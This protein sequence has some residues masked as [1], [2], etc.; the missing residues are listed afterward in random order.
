MR[1][2]LAAT[3]QNL[4]DIFANNQYVFEI[5]L[6]QR[7]Y[8]WT[9]EHID[10][11]LD[12]LVDAM[13]RDY[14]APYFLGSVVL[15][16]SNDDPRS[17]VV[18]GQQRLT[19]LTMLLCV[20]RELSQGREIAN[21]LDE[22]VREKGSQLKRTKDRLRLSLRE[23]DREFFQRNVQ[24][25]GG[26]ESFLNSDP[27]SYSDS[28]KQIFK[29]VKYL[30]RKLKELDAERRDKLADFVSYNCYLVIVSASDTDSAYRIFSVMNDRGLDLSATD[31]L[32]AQI[33]S[34]L[35][36]GTQNNY[37]DRWESLEEGLGRDDFRDL[38]AHIRMIY[39][40]DKLRGTLQAEFREH[41]LEELGPV[42]AQRFLDEVLEPYAHCYEIVSRASYEST[43]DAD[44]VNTLLQ[45]LKRLDN[46]DWIPPAVAYFGREVQQD[47]LLKFTKYLD[48]L[49]YGLFIRRA[50]LTQR[51]NRYADVLR[52]IERNDNLFDETSPLQ[53]SQT[54]KSEILTRLDG[55]LYSLIRV[56]RPLLL[57]LDSL[58]TDPGVGHFLGHY[59]ESIISIEHVL[60]QNPA[61]GS[62]WIEW[63]PN[64]E[65]RAQWTHRLANL[66]LLSRRKNTRASNFDAIR[67][68][69]LDFQAMIGENR[70]IVGG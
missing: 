54:E 45:H 6:Y 34:E 8:A 41:V 4:V 49:A 47:K 60:P 30:N 62:Q 37:A 68:Y 70:F 55:D 38:F 69:G 12:D 29:N 16:K 13:D 44:K 28:Q 50:N 42:T 59:Q 35:P 5:P 20:L 24:N 14:D 51:V 21:Q 57:R 15:I 46:F 43:K 22:F 33:I 9:V 11:L 40:K 61:E 1:A 23:L 52:A 67:S 17:E 58:L 63:F 3:E 66:V 19:T 53:L 18:D 27:A 56:R 7:P 26:L 64:A 48:R 10:E 25:R 31:I 39:R 2:T 65:E 36:K 32:K